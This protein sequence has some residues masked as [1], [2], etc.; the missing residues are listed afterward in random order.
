VTP[1]GTA[2]GTVLTAGP[3]IVPTA[4]RAVGPVTVAYGDR[5]R[6]RPDV[7]PEAI[8]QG[9]LRDGDPVTVD[10]Y[11]LLSRLGAGGMADVF[12][13]VSP[14]GRPV[15][16]KV[17]RAF[18]GASTSC[19]REFRLARSA[20]PDVTAPALCHGV[21]AEGSYLVTAYLPDHRCAATLADQVLATDR[22][23]ELG[24]ALA[25]ALATIHTRGVVHCDVKPANL[26]FHADDVRLIDFGI[27]RYVDEPGDPAG[28]LEGTVR[29]SPGWAAPEQRLGAPVT[30][31]VDVFAWGC[32]LACLSTGRRPL[33][34]SD[35]AQDAWARS[36]ARRSALPTGL[37]AAIHAALAPD[38]ADRPSA[39]RLADLCAA[40]RNGRRRRVLRGF[41]DR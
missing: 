40:E 10:G 16:V 35:A 6:G 32:V 24:S 26:L 14:T 20:G 30:P 23:I 39:R 19:G 13:A 31:A 17:L 18:A 9:P 8:G 2:A 22:L 15:T 41:M 33:P 5:R 28:E 29:C 36:S 4:G 27:A 34:D 38:P 3:V 25:G 12:R 1:P 11:R 7:P 37:G 21:S